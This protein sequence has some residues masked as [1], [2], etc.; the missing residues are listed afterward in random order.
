MPTPIFKRMN[1][2]FTPFDE[3]L[4]LPARE[5]ERKIVMTHEYFTIPFL[6]RSQSGYWSRM[7][8]WN[9]LRF[10]GVK[11]VRHENHG[12]QNTIFSNIRTTTNQFLENPAFQ[13]ARSLNFDSHWRTQ[14]WV[15]FCY[16]KSQDNPPQLCKCGRG[17][18]GCR[19]REVACGWDLMFSLAQSISRFTTKSPTLPASLPELSRGRGSRVLTGVSLPSLNC[20]E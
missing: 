10:E 4:P 19:S 15:L 3:S 20:P 18:R 16:V 14:W 9:E 12:L 7:K 11:S 17:Y 6:N 13:P 2:P 5:Q 1:R 8:D